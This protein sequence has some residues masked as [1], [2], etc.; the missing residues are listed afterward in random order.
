MKPPSDR[1]KV[2]VRISW[3]LILHI[4]S[5]PFNKPRQ[6]GTHLSLEWSQRKCF[7]ELQN[8]DGLWI[9]VYFY[10]LLIKIFFFVF[11]D[12]DDF[13]S[14]RLITVGPVWSDL[15]KFRQF[16]KILVKLFRVYFAFG[17]I[18]NVLWQFLWILGKFELL[19][20]AK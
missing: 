11:R 2:S 7:K 14:P 1:Y 4:S 9:F 10:F 16:S 8:S 5:L 19:W 3:G 6:V 13:S 15:A 18:V 20:A 12:L 17:K